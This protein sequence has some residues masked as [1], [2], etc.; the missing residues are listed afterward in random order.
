MFSKILQ[1]FDS[2][3]EEVLVSCDNVPLCPLPLTGHWLHRGPSTTLYLPT[4]RQ[5]EHT[6]SELLSAVWM[7]TLGGRA[8]SSDLR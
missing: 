2:D 4:L 5:E 1:V 6:F 7:T 8:H 3:G